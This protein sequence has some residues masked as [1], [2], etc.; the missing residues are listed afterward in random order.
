MSGEKTY[1]TYCG[2]G[3]ERGEVTGV[4]L[5]RVTGS[6]SLLTG[7]RLQMVEIRQS[8]GG[9]DV[10]RYIKSSDLEEESGD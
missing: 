6:V 2:Y 8:N 9:P 7:E 5:S 3:L 1:V 4:V 10:T